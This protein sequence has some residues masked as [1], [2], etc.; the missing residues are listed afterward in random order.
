MLDQVLKILDLWYDFWLHRQSMLFSFK[1]IEIIWSYCFNLWCG[2]LRITC[3][4]LKIYPC[5]ISPIKLTNWLY[6]IIMSRTRFRVNL[7]SIVAWMSRK[8]L[9]A[10]S[11]PNY[12]AVL[13]VLV[14]TVRLTLCYYHVTYAFQTESTIYSCLNVKE[15]LVRNRCDIRCWHLL[16][17]RYRACFEQG[18]P[19]HSVNYRV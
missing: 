3:F 6:V 5:F 2:Q 15:H 10:T 14:C 18:V 11:K 16:N 17:F 1:L 19:W 12:W 4:T 8:S 13:W 7:Y 9:L